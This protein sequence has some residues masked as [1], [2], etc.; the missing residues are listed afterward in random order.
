MIVLSV[1]FRKINHVFLLKE[2]IKEFND[3]L[4]HNICSKCVCVCV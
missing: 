2:Q 3:H 4:K 1:E